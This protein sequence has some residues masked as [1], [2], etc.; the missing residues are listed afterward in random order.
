MTT[1]LIR[2]DWQHAKD[3]GNH[4]TGK[5]WGPWVFNRRDLTLEY[6]QLGRGIYEVDLERATTSAQILD[7]L[8]QISGK[9]WCSKED[10]GYL[11][12]ALDD[13]AWTLQ[14]KVCGCGH[15]HGP[16]DWRALYPRKEA[17]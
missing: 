2:I 8:A 4:R 5:K 16:I 10:L 12:K 3:G 9:T 14:S 1:K 11:V 6:G 13:L 15:E 17:R 7:W